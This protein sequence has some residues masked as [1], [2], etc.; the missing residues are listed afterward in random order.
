MYV[1]LLS[2]KN[3]RDGNGEIRRSTLGHENMVFHNCIKNG[4]DMDHG[5][6]TFG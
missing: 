3:S 4:V 6:A 5:I 1:H 2:D